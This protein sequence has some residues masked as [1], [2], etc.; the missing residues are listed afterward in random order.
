MELQSRTNS[1]AQFR[2]PPP[3]PRPL[4]QVTMYSPRTR[5]LNCVSFSRIR[6]R[7]PFL[8]IAPANAEAPRPPPTVTISKAR[9][10]HGKLLRGSVS[11]GGRHFCRDGLSPNA[12][13]LPVAKLL[14]KEEML[15]ENFG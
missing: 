5:S 12:A 11:Q 10:M 1:A 8:A 6:T 13:M 9:G 2:C 4:P 3:S 14:R 7:T 15:P